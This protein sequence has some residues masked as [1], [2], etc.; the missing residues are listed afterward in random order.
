[1]SD[2]LSTALG[3]LARIAEG[4]RAESTGLSSERDIRAAAARHRRQLDEVLKVM[5]QLPPDQ[6]KQLGQAANEVKAKLEEI[7]EMR[8]RGLAGEA[9]AADLKRTIDV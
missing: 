8:L 5:R 1:M 4:L 6:K 2:V 7:V 9:R 3:D